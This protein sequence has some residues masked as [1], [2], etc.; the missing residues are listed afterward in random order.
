MKFYFLK[1]RPTNTFLEFKPTTIN[2][3][4]MNVGSKN[5]ISGPIH[6]LASNRRPPIKCR[7]VFNFS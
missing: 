4:T 6:R 3:K 2:L 7:Q 1:C 5:T